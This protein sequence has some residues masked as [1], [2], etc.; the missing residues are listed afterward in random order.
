MSKNLNTK[1]IYKEITIEIINKKNE[2]I[3]NDEVNQ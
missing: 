3:K 2:E 1:K